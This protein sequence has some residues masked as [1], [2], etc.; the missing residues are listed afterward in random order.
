MARKNKSKFVWVIALIN[1]DNLKYCGWELETSLK[2][3]S[4]EFYVPQLRILEKKHKNKK[5]FRT[6]LLLFNYGFFKVPKKKLKNHRYFNE[7]KDEVSCISGYLKNR[8]DAKSKI[9]RKGTDESIPIAVADQHHITHLKKIEEANQVFTSEELSQVKEGD[10]IRL[11][12]YPFE[13]ML[14]NII[15]IDHKKQKVKVKIVEELYSHELFNV[16][17]LEFENVFFSIYSQ[18]TDDSLM[19]LKSLDEIASFNRNH[20]VF[21]DHE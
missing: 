2:F 12:G 15:K 10:H 13:G 1:K 8:A 21:E 20:K 4:V 9:L 5:V 18:D 14:A 11:R 17:E 7:L 16:V 3:H 6:V 19:G